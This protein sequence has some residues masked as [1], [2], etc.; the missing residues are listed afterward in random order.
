MAHFLMAIQQ[1]DFTNVYP[2]NR[3][4]SKALYHIFNVITREFMR[5][6]SEKE[7]NFHFLKTVVEHSGVP[8]LAY[9][10]E[11]EE[12]LLAN[13]ALKDLLHLTLY[14]QS[15]FVGQRK[16]GAFKNNP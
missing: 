15:R 5:L 4:K 2:E 14:Q 11:D 1:N 8:L 7:F 16:R 13:Q 9:N 10:I 3:K 6:R 12:V